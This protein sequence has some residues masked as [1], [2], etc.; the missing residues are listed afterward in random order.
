MRRTSSRR[1]TRLHPGQHG[2]RTNCMENSTQ[3][4]LTPRSTW[5]THQRYGRFQRSECPDIW[6]RPPRHKWPKSWS[7][8]EDIQSF[9]LSGICTVILWQ[10]CYAKGNSRKFYWNTVGKSFLTSN[11]SLSTNQEDYYFLCM[12][13]KPAWLASHE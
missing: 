9:V 4:P 6:I 13:T 12:W 5:K 8:M 2:R 1:S 10:D 11:I 3:Y 7:G